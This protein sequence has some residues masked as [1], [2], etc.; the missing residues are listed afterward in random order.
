VWV[1]R[2]GRGFQAKLQ[3]SHKP[4]TGETTQERAMVIG[5]HTAQRNRSELIVQSRIGRIRI[6]NSYGNDPSRRKG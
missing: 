2:A 6:K 3:G 1:V 4:L 5:R